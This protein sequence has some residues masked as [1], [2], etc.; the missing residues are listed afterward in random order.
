MSGDA[1]CRG[2]RRS[3]NCLSPSRV[4]ALV[5]NQSNLSYSRGQSAPDKTVRDCRNFPERVNI[6]R[7]SSRSSTMRRLITANSPELWRSIRLTKI[8]RCLPLAAASAD[9]RRPDADARTSPFS[10]YV[11]R[12][13]IKSDAVKIV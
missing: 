5:K 6:A 11:R 12:Q 4:I 9:N 10:S 13:G 2:S 1:R 8:V 7:S 3:V